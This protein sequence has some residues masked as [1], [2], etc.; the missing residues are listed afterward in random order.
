MRPACLFSLVT[1][2]GALLACSSESIDRGGGGGSGGSGASGGS[3]GSSGSSGTGGSVQT[4]DYTQSACYGQKATTEVYDLGTHV[5]RA[6]TTTCRAEG[7]RTRFYVADELWETQIDPDAPVLGQAEVNAFMVRYELSGE[8]DSAYPELGVLPTDEKVFGVLSPASLTDDK[9]PIFVVDS[10]GAGDGYLCSWC[11]QP[12]LHLDG[13]SLRSLH[14][15]KALSIAAHETYHAI[16]RGYDPNEELWVDE[17]LAEAAMTVNGFFTDQVWLDDFLRN[18]NQNWGV[19]SASPQEFHYG[20]GLLFGT[21]LWELG[22]GGLLSAITHEPQNGWTGLDR[23]LATQR[24]GGSAFEHFT[25]MALAMFIDDPATGYDFQSF[26][27]RGKILPYTLS[28]GDEYSETIEPYGIMFV[29]FAEGAAG[30]EFDTSGDVTARLVL[31]ATPLDVRELAPGK[32]APFDGKAPRVLMLTA[33]AR[34]DVL[35]TID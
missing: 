3:S 10:N 11:A 14:T 34:T 18:T 4:P 7:A 27:L 12:A 24:I 28:A 15:D 31:D 29:T 8:T 33:K 17:S 5:P 13:P 1:L 32:R 25:D 22:G 2:A 30:V 6:V 20:A 16:H 9:L 19:G 35:L 23:S 26:D 21:Y